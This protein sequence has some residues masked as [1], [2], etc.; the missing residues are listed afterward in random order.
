MTVITKFHEKN[1]V[2]MSSQEVSA[3]TYLA[4]TGADVV[5][6]TTLTGAVTY[7]TAALLYLGDSNSRN[8]VTYQKDSYADVTLE[9]PQQILG[10][11][12]PSILAANVPLSDWLQAS[13][14]TITVNGDGSVLFANTTM[15]PLTLS[16]DYRKSTAQNAVNQKLI[17]FYGCQ[18]IVDVT[19]NIG[20]VPRLKFAVKGNA[21]SPIES[22]ILTPTYGTQVQSVGA[23]IR[24]NSIVAAQ[25][26]PLGEVFTAQASLGTITTITR[27]GNIATVT[28]STAHGL[29]TNRYV[30]ISASVDPLYNGDFQ[31]SVLST[32]TF[33]YVMQATPAASP[34]T[35][36][37][38]AKI[39]GYA[40]NFCHADLSAPNFFGRD[41]TRYQTGCEEGF[42]STA[43]PSDVTVKMLEAE[44]TN[45][46]ITGITFITTAA[47]VTAPSHGMVTGDY[48]IVSGATGVDAAIYNGYYKVTVLTSSTFSYTMLSTPAGIATGTLIGVDNNRVLFDPDLNISG[49]FT[50]QLKFGTGV[51]KYTTYTWNTLQLADVKE[52]KVGN[53]FGREVKFRNTG[54]SSILLS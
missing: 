10:V 34:A 43:V 28:M 47:T 50:V 20:D 48:V 18:A 51:G 2:L 31:I 15:N 35:G 3:G 8:E 6:A 37:P 33:S 12:N 30:N 5:A 53:Y 27:V 14:A 36:T 41:L 24:Q 21:Y 13:G 32:T 19:A 29:L 25:I 40:K 23:P 4:P 1:I 39:G 9:T 11:L 42:A 46:A 22:A 7:V 26:A 44:A 45:F 16:I 17:Q 52:A 49:F 38:L 54:V